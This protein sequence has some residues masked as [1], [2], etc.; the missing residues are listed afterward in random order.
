MKL[1]EIATKYVAWAEQLPRVVHSTRSILVLVTPYWMP[2]TTDESLTITISR[3]HRNLRVSDGGTVI[4]FLWSRGIDVHNRPDASSRLRKMANFLDIC[5]DSG[6]FFCFVDEED[7]A[8]I[9]NVCACFGTLISVGLELP[10]VFKFKR[11]R[12]SPKRTIR[13][14]VRDA[15]LDV[16]IPVSPVSECLLQPQEGL[17]YEEYP[18][19]VT[20]LS[21]KFSFYASNGMENALD[22]LDLTKTT[23]SMTLQQKACEF[24]A[25]NEKGRKKLT[26]RWNYGVIHNQRRMDISWNPIPFLRD[27]DVQLFNTQNSDDMERLKEQYRKTVSSS[28]LRS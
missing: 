22:V 4:G 24:L 8:A 27:E 1:S 17:V 16:G 19:T 26:G 23:N 14:V 18:D 21:H 2:G 11:P 10:A 12:L 15:F 28:L 5:Y 13:R 25:I 9:H 7:P 6:E 20:G 3:K